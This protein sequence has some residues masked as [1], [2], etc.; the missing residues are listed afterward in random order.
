MQL[1]KLKHFPFV[2]FIVA[3]N[4]INGINGN[5]KWELIIVTMKTCRTETTVFHSLFVRISRCAG[6]K[7]AEANG[8][9]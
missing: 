7:V 1:F 3:L 2:V 9:T 4:G 8:F 6:K 5:N